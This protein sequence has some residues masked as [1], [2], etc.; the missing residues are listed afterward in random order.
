M[1]QLT[2]QMF[3]PATLY[4]ACWKRTHRRQSSSTII[5]QV[6]LRLY[7]SDD[8]ITCRLKDVLA[9]VEVRVLDHIVVGAE[10][11]ESFAERGLL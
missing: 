4:A 9:L 5:H 10:G 11:C 1:E 6:S 2:V 8:L 3:I 7:R